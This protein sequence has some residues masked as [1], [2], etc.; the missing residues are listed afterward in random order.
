MPT[1]V[2]SLP[3]LT[4]RQRL[5]K[6]VLWLGTIAFV[7]GAISDNSTGAW[8]IAKIVPDAWKEF[9]VT[10][11]AT[12]AGIA[13]FYPHVVFAGYWIANKVIEGANIWRDDP[14]EPLDLPAEL[15]RPPAPR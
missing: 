2:P 14:I 7:L 1:P 12:L 13:R 3:R 11:G 9:A 4:W 10:T 5:N 15:H 8:W 6:F